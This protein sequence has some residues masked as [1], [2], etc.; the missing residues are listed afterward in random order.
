MADVAS[1]KIRR[2]YGRG[3]FDGLKAGGHDPEV[4][5]TTARLRKQEE[6]LTEIA[7]AILHAVPVAQR[8]TAEQIHAELSRTKHQIAVNA[9]TLCLANLRGQG[10]VNEP[11]RGKFCRVT[12]SQKVTQPA[13]TKP[14]KPS[15]RVVGGGMIERV[16]SIGQRLRALGEQAIA[17][18]AEVE[19]LALD[20]DAKIES[21]QVDAAKLRQL[22]QLL[23]SIGQ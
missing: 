13:P 7:R 10:L 3:F 23:K 16:S 18:A 6:G 5:M 21:N 20:I 19:E 1:E 11:E 4:Y 22:Q 8:W 17:I 12:E 14:D 2:T 15:L 9:V